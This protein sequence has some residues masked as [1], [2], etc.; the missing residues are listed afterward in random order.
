MR[1]LLNLREVVTGLLSSP[2]EIAMRYR[3]VV[4]FLLHVAIFIFAYHFA[5]ILR[6]DFHIPRTYQSVIR[7]TIPVLLFAKA[8]GF[9]AFGLFSG[10]WRYVSIRD[11]LPITGGC[12]LGSALFAGAVSLY[13]GPYHVP[14][15]IYFLDWGNTLLLVLA[16]RFVIRSGREMLGRQHRR[17]DRRVLIVGAGLAGQMIAREIGENPSLGMIEMGFVDDDRAKIGSRIHGLRVLGNHE[18]IEEICRKRDIDEIIIAIP[19]APPSEVRHIVEH[20]RTL[21]ARFRILPSVG[22]LI[23]GMVSV[24]ALR[25]LD[26]EDLLGRD[27]VAL[28]T[29]LLRRDITGHVVM[30]TGAAGSIGSELCRQV[31]GL[32]PAKLVMFEIAETPLFELEHDMRA[33]YP[34][35]PL[36]SVIGDIRDRRRVEDV[37]AE[38][39]PTLVYHAAAYKHVPVMEMH[40]VEAVKT[41]VLGTRILAEIAARCGVQRFV[42]VSTDKAVRPTNVMGATKRVAELIIQNMNGN[43]YD[44]VFVA[45]RFGNVLDSSGSVIPIF[46]KQLETTGKLTVT[47]PEASRYFMLIPEAAGLILQAGSMG[48]GSEVFVLDMGEPVKIV[49]LAKNL[50]RLSG[51]ELGVN[52][53]MVFT[54]LRPGEKLREELVVEGEDVIRTSHPQVMKLIGDGHMPEDW[55]RQLNVLIDLAIR[56][57]RIGVV[58]Q[59]N[60]LVKGYTPHYG[61]HGIESPAED[62]PASPVLVSP[63]SSSIH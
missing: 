42:L 49:E 45:V 62:M 11:I 58:R 7:D 51:K 2:V 12:T 39:A 4:K 8:L 16:G 47:D 53:E 27:P 34:R 29:E 32:G 37:F 25:D 1:K 56:G 30:V 59:L 35:V 31:A 33:K 48:Q 55:T 15:S 44:T 14:R 17:S 52:A 46:R 3:G 6:F 21:P 24:K 50:I 9:L 60:A 10:W 22:D 5:Y 28:D 20:C 19:S 61:F 13:W 57:D 41:N 43:G 36:V 23:G 40:P 63:P 18:K 38:H 54:G 26:L